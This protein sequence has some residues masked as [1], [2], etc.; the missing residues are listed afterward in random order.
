VA[1]RALQGAAVSAMMVS[2]NAVLADS[3]EPA[4]RGKAMGIFMIPTREPL[5]VTLTPRHTRHPT[6][7]TTAHARLLPFRL[8]PAPG[9][10]G[11]SAGAS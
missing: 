1:L 4:Q 11:R 3:W 7:R 5:P 10:L 8:V 6:C 9:D 2:S